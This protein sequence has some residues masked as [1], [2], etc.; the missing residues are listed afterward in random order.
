M[1]YDGINGVG[2]LILIA[3]FLAVT[4]VFVWVFGSVGIIISIIFFLLCLFNIFTDDKSDTSKPKSKPRSKPVQ[5]KNIDVDKLRQY[6]L[7]DDYA[8]YLVGDLGGALAEAADIENASDEELI[9]M[10][11][12]Q[13]ID[14]RKFEV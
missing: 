14:L 6:M 9:E 1:K 8:A 4:A 7:D 13:G 10:A 11:K 3:G 12:R 2:C 5:S